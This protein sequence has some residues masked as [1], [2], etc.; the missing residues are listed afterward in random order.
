M[1]RATEDDLEAYLRDNKL[2]SEEETQRERVKTKRVAVKRIK[3]PR[4]KVQKNQSRMTNVHMG[5]EWLAKTT[6]GS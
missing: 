6:G 1:S 3:G 4:K 5:N 2:L